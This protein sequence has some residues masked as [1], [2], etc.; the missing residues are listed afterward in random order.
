MR[1]GSWTGVLLIGGVLLTGAAEVT[2]GGDAEQPAAIRVTLEEGRTPDGTLVAIR[3]SLE[4]GGGGTCGRHD[5][6][7]VEFAT[8]GEWV[9][10]AAAPME[11][12]PLGLDCEV[13]VDWRDEGPVVEVRGGKIHTERQA[14]AAAGRQEPRA[15]VKPRRERV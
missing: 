10:T 12:R 6:E 5:G 4:G 13:I 11:Y 1:G 7:G 8:V 15:E 9:A 14:P 3:V 2:A